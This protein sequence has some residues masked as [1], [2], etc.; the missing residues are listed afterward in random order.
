[1]EEEKKE[2]LEENKSEDTTVI[3][4]SQLD[5][6]LARLDEMESANKM[7]IETADKARMARYHAAHKEHVNRRCRLTVWDKKIII[8]WR[9]IEDLVE[10]DTQGRWTETVIIELIDMEGEKYTVPYVNYARR[11]EKIGAEILSEKKEDDKIF[12]KVKTDS[13]EE[14]TLE[15]TFVN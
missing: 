6:I 1:M 5:G 4:T 2:P 14:L 9:M 11:H 15:N 8:G 3:P 10:Q 13:G 12:F 7:L